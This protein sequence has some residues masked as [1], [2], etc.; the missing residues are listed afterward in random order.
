MTVQDPR[1]TASGW[2]G[3]NH[4]DLGKIDPKVLAARS[5]DMCLSM[6]NP[7][8]IEPGRYTVILE[9]Q[10]T[11]DLFAP[12]M[13]EMDR[14]RAEDGKGPFAGR[15]LGRSKINEQVMDRRLVL[16]SDPMDP[17]GG[18]VP[19]TYWDGTPYQPVTWINQGVLRELAYPK[20]YALAALNLD[21][22]LPNPYSYRLSTAPGVSTATVE[23]M[24]ASTERGILV[25]RFHRV[26]VMDDSSMLCEGF[27]RDGIWLI[28][29]GKISRPVKN[30]RFT[31]S[32]LFV[33][34]KLEQVGVSQRVF[35]PWQAVVAPAIR[36]NDFSFTSLAESA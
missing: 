22:A 3:V 10:A 29:H 17:D 32:P 7:S 23:E 16:G 26:K 5:L 28:E 36:V 12:I 4:Y 6:Q 20:S 33:L 19:Y 2:A 31:E 27:T 14:M 8:A 1:S 15:S 35:A 18:F 13:G 25:A 21:K 34:N 9:P 30:F 24:I 11:A